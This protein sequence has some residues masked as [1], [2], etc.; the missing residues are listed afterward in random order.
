MAFGD[1][2]GAFLH[3]RVWSGEYS[4]IVRLRVFFFGT[5]LVGY[6]WPYTLHMP[7]TEA[8]ILYVFLFLC[9]R[10]SSHFFFSSQLTVTQRAH[11]ASRDLYTGM[12]CGLAASLVVYHF[13]KSFL[14]TFWCPLCCECATNYISWNFK[15]FPGCT[16]RTFYRLISGLVSVSNK[17]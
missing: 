10:Y 1:H 5:C 4:Y 13:K 9:L 8:L 12:R 16:Y 15:V 3:E 2:F 14:A 6:V 17:Y 7:C 11:C